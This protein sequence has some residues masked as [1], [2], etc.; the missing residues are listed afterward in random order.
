MRLTRL[1]PA[2]TA[3]ASVAVLFAVTLPDPA[4]P[5]PAEVQD[6]AVSPTPLPLAC[7]GPLEVPVGDIDTGD[8]DLDAGS[9]DRDFWVSPDG[10]N[11]AEGTA[12]D[13]AWGAQVERVGGGD[14]AS[15]AGTTCMP[16]LQDQWLVAG[17][18]ALGASA[19]LVLTNTADTVTR[20]HVTLYG[21]VGEVAEPIVVSVAP[22]GQE[23]ILL[24]GVE[25]EVPGLAVRVVAGGVGVAAALQ[26]SRLD[27]FVAA[28]T[29]WA[30]PTQ[31]G[32][33]LIVP[34]AGPVSASSPAAVRL[35]APDG[36]H[37]SLALWGGDGVRTWLG[38]E[39][40]DLEPGTV[41]DL[42]LP[43]GDVQAVSIE[44]DAPVAAAA[45]VSVARQAAPD[46]GVD[47]ALDIAWTEAQVVTDEERAVVVP[48]GDVAAVVAAGTAGR[49]T[50]TDLGGEVVLDE[51]V[52]AETVQRFG[53]DVEPGTV[54]LATDRVAWALAVADPD[55]GFITTLSPVATTV[56]DRL[57]S[58][59]P[60]GYVGS[61]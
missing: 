42:V 11:A 41:T 8:A 37:V 36:A 21:P 28:G 49:L 19:R 33:S 57:V 39:G 58:I 29:E 16:P 51:P 53:L 34:V 10:D 14:I 50:L 22:H 4:T 15:L 52:A 17:S 3:M 7:P 59:V 47:N 30:A 25:A 24:E 27:G 9:S 20:A 12:I 13:G 61:P 60:G 55:A 48:D 6:V 32:E 5:A 54:L 2:V 18:T 38:E 45:R 1:V 26:D 40:V 23:S 35:I 44:A 46:T 31:A 43:D 56:P